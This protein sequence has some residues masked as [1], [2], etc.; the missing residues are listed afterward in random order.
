MNRTGSGSNSY[1]HIAA[2]AAGIVLGATAHAAA[3]TAA[4]PADAI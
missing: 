1:R 2:L 4:L 3:R